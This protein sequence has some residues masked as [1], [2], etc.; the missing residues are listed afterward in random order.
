MTKW[1]LGQLGKTNPIQTQYKANSN[2]IKAKTNPIQSQTNP[3]S[4]E[5]SRDVALKTVKIRRKKE[6]RNKP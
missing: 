6:S 3:I 2:P 1:T 5:K 4:K